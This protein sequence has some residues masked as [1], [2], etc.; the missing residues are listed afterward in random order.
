MKEVI[1][2]RKKN[3]IRY[4]LCLVVAITMWIGLKYNKY[5]EEKRQIKKICQIEKKAQEKLASIEEAKTIKKINGKKEEKI[6]EQNL[7]DTTEAVN[8]TV[9]LINDTIITTVTQ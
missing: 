5:E 2:Q 6:S 4:V 8:D 7:S 3:A 9:K 1:K